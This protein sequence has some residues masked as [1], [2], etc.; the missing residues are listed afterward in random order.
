MPSAT[1]LGGIA[2][3][4]LLQ[5]AD[6][7][8]TAGVAVQAFIAD[9]AADSRGRGSA[10]Q[11]TPALQ[12][13]A[14]VFGQNEVHVPP[15]RRV[16]AGV[17]AVGVRADALSTSLA[18]HWSALGPTDRGLLVYEG[19]RGRTGEEDPARPVLRLREDTTLSAAELET[20]ATRAPTGT[21]LR[22]LFSQCQSAGLL[23]LIR[24]NARDERGL[25]PYNRCGFATEPARREVIAGACGPQSTVP[26][27]TARTYTAQFLAALIGRGADRDGDRSVTL[28]EA[29]LH[30]LIESDDGDLP[31]ATSE[32]Y[33]ERWQPLWLR[34]ADTLGEPDN[35][36]GR[37]ASTL[38]E[39]LRLPAHGRALLNALQTRQAELQARVERQQQMVAGL[40][41]RIQHGQDSIR[42][43]L[44]ERWPDATHP[45]TAAYARFLANDLA[46]AQA[47]I[48]AH[49]A[50]ATLV[51]DQD[52]RA[53]LIEDNAAAERAQ[54]RLAKVL[55]LRQLARLLDQ[56]ERHA[57]AQSRRDYQRLTRCENTPL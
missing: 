6:Q 27:D 18:R 46:S 25:A 39:R 9:P 41:E 10:G 15:S 53:R 42:R 23:H 16:P 55:R 5:A 49:Q 51:S 28:H 4:S 2:E 34:H 37:L 54:A 21:A 38:A 45:H 13:L 19:P 52:R 32:V 44:L 14:R 8:R 22:F 48:T 26:V 1:A 7:F 30:A 3:T 40:D 12:P 47:F 57:A 36:Y 56:F 43:A 24:P 29:H 35:V 31:R 33:L 11:V 17:A 20:L 50:W